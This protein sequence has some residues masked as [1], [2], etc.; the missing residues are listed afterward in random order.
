MTQ[1]QT[2]VHEAASGS[3]SGRTA[4][5]TGAASGIGAAI[6]DA[7]AEAGARLCWSIGR[8]RGPWTGGRPVAARGVEVVGLHVDVAVEGNVERMFVE[9]RQRVGDVD[10]L[11]NNA[12]ILTECRVV[13]MPPRCSTR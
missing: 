1:Q 5:V 4:L 10:V 11:V 6:A 2:R 12:G 7:Y 3:L 13:D 9:A 8:R